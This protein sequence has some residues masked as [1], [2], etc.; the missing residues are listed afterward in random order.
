MSTETFGD[1]MAALGAFRKDCLGGKPSNRAIARALGVVPQ[2]VTNWFA[3]AHFPG[4]DAGAP[5]KIV[6]MIKASAEQQGV[7]APEG[8]LDVDRWQEAHRAEAARRQGRASDT[9]VR[10]RA[11]RA[12]APGLFLDEAADP[13]RF[14]VHRP[15]RA[16][17][18]YSG[19]SALPPYARR[20]HDGELAEVT[21]AAR[22]GRSGIA[23]LVGG[24]STGKTRACWETL[25]TLATPA[26]PNGSWR[27]WHPLEPSPAKAAS[28]ALPLVAPRTVIWL[29]EAQRYLAPPDGSGEELAAGL[30]ELLRDP[31]R[32]PVLILATLWDGEWRKLTGHPDSG[33]PDS[34]ALARGLLSGHEIIVPASFSQDDLRELAGAGDP[35]LR[36]AARMAPD[37]RI[38]QF[39]AGAPDLLTRYHTA[40]RVT[41]ALITAAM[42]ARRLGMG[43][44][45]PLSF[46]EAAV[47]AYLDDEGLETIE[48]Q[49]DWLERALAEAVKRAKGIPGPL[50]RIRPKGQAASPGTRYRL[51]DYLDEHGRRERHTKI[52][53][54]EFWDAIAVHAGPGDLWA[55]AHAARS[56]GLLRHAA[57][58]DKRAALHGDAAAALA[59]VKQMRAND[60]DMESLPDQIIERIG[61]DQLESIPDL[62]NIL[63]WSGAARQLSLL[64][65]RSPESFAPSGGS[66]WAVLL[67]RA[68][69]QAGAD[70]RAAD[71]GEWLAANAGV[72]DP[73]EVAELI[74][75]LQDAGAQQ[76]LAVLL[77]R[78]PA[79]HVTLKDTES[80]A[81]LAGRLAEAGAAGQ[82][83]V[84]AA[85]V[86]QSFPAGDPEAADR[87]AGG[88]ATW[89]VDNRQAVVALTSDLVAHADLSDPRFVADL[90]R[91]LEYGDA[92][93]QVQLLLQR[94]PASSVSLDNT[95]NVVRLL[96]TFGR[97][98]AEEQIRVLMT[99]HPA[100][101]VSPGDLAGAMR[102]TGCL[103]LLG[104]GEHADA[105]LARAHATQ[106]SIED[107]ESVALLLNAYLSAGMTEQAAALLARDPASHVLLDDSQKVADLL[108]ALSAAGA[109]AQVSSLAAR[110]AADTVFRVLWTPGG[111][112]KTMRETGQGAQ[113]DLFEKRI[114][115]EGKLQDHNRDGMTRYRFGREPDGTPAEPWGWDDLL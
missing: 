114:L 47:P 34:H 85:R 76:Q 21:G 89:G 14:E 62:I 22:D 25:K 9:A 55:L 112:P 33:E 115:D 75:M 83:A 26:I 24:S 101:R 98:G 87:L 45:I 64:L 58:M 2:T 93:E 8:L 95:G 39:I 102:L 97:V 19:L 84:L 82:L 59:L 54:A 27:L 20:E 17:G 48:D 35:R 28:Q 38:T 12:A 43:E 69:L 52:P 51:A 94:D 30:W 13:F 80:I 66:Y 31:S 113:A 74:E 100:S 16:Q 73:G 57:S 10:T 41:K 79:A 1:L 7:S 72:S 109:R 50:A 71:L 105:V 29:N 108:R 49:D 110:A 77:A 90:L 5:V 78:D 60:A 32:G 11:Q 15:V 53:P 61:L 70:E 99:R 111:L 56:R 23:V 104:F 46:L 6:R 86:A 106:V 4:Q 96:E 36:Q 91:V 40:G 18:A 3:G 37:G 103:R 63:H 88:L 92:A 81:F 107:P 65:A 67:A 42:D 44:A 68:L